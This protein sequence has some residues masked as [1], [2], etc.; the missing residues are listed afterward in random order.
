MFQVSIRCK[1]VAGEG[2]DVKDMCIAG[3]CSM[4][5]DSEGGNMVPAKPVRQQIDVTKMK[6]RKVS[7][8]S[9]M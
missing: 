8:S 3:H 1:Q 2:V 4:Q 5:G 6:V 7:S 9:P